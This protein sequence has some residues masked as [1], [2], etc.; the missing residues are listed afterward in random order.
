MQIDIKLEKQVGVH[1]GGEFCTFI[2]NVGGEIQCD[3]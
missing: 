2:F 3:G 1:G